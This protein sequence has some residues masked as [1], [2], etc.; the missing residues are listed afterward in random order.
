MKTQ[1]PSIE[2]KHFIPG[3]IRL[4]IKPSV[5]E[6]TAIKDAISTHDGI[7]MQQY[8]PVTG[9][10]LIRYDLHR[11]SEKEIMLRAAM[12][13]S[14]THGT[15]LLKVGQ[16]N[17]KSDFLPALSGL[18]L[19]F[20]GAFKLAPFNVSSY[21]TLEQLSS[22]CTMTA[23]TQ[24]ALDEVQDNGHV[25]PE[26]FSIFYLLKSMAQSNYYT[27]ALITWFATF[28]RHLWSSTNNKVLVKLENDNKLI[29]STLASKNNYEKFL[30]I[31]KKTIQTTFEF[32][33]S[34]NPGLF[35]E[36]KKLCLGH[37]NEIEGIKESK[38]TISVKFSERY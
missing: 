30:L 27:P 13:V 18:M 15:T 33:Q 23:V 38:N 5:K 17:F 10:L 35:C 6:A 1:Y 24:H 19:I 11:I 12:A 32:D 16:S 37:K 8:N 34:I 31:I 20:T 14:K 25:D 36:L 4:I 29:I 9:S 3:R 2:L 22:F 28:A 21:K 26:V 7:Q